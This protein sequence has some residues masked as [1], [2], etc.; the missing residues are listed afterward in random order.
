MPAR[1]RSTCRAT[2]RRYLTVYPTETPRPTV[3]SVNFPAGST[4]GNFAIAELG[5]DGK[6]AIYNHDGTVDVVLDVDGYVR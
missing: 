2:S 6:L 5:T 3:S 1:V 4:V